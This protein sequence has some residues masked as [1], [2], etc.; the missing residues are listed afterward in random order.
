[1]ETHIILLIIGVA[2]G[3][4]LSWTAL[5]PYKAENLEHKKRQ[6]L[7]EAKREAQSV[8]EEIRHE[9][10]QRKQ[11]ILEEN[12]RRQEYL[13]RWEESLQL[14]ERHVES[15]L[16]KNKQLKEAAQEAENAANDLKAKSQEERQWMMQQ[17]FDKTHT[18]KESIVD[19]AKMRVRNAVLDRKD[20]YIQRRI[21]VAEDDNVKNAKTVLTNVLQRYTDESSV[22]HSTTEVT[23]KQERFKPDFIGEKADLVQ[24]FEELIDVEI[25]FNDYPKII[26]I[27]GYNLLKRQIARE[28]VDLLQNE[29]P[30]LTRKHI[31]E[32]VKKGEK[33][34]HDTM[35]KRALQACQKIGLKDVP[36]GLLHYIGRLHFRTSY[37]QNA[38]KHCLEVG[39]FAGLIAAE[40]GANVEIARISGFFHDVGKAISEESDKGHDVL[41]KEILEEFK[42][43]EEI[44]HAAWVHH[45]AEPAK[46]PEAKIV[47]AAD[48]LSASRPGA[49][50][51]SLER[52]LQR[53][54]DLEGAALSFS[55]VKKTFAISAGREIRV[56]VKPEQVNDEQMKE[57]AHSIAH[58]IESELTYPGNVKVNLIRR[59]EWD[60]TAQGAMPESVPAKKKKAFDSKGL[61]SNR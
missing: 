2:L 30:P 33:N 37:G 27:G 25:I 56:I 32:A 13:K 4:G 10:T 36:E 31:E 41:T 45:E 40:V 55:G 28:A 6:L 26:T 8:R 44:I 42:Y 16:Q 7:E 34:I 14:K 15:R 18:T 19:D 38:L 47:M 46:T 9:R 50:L 39:F 51:E 60:A 3:G 24:Y 12:E 54:R 59:R 1:M 57:L 23:V 35:K 53:I 58:K 48:A 21:A 61:I 29:R 5:R 17:L 22:D 52:Y 49:R 11:S 43:P 20:K